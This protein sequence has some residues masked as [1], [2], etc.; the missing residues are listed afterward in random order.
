MLLT[1]EVRPCFVVVGISIEMLVAP[2][3]VFGIPVLVGMLAAVDYVLL[4]FTC[5]YGFSAIVR[6]RNRRLLASGFAAALIVLHAFVRNRCNCGYCA[7]CES[8]EGH[9]RWH[10]EGLN[11]IGH[12]GWL[13]VFSDSIVT[14]PG[15][16]ICC[17]PKR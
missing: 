5:V 12:F 8:N 14:G 2:G 3:A 15:A 16:V 11:R 6:A 1:A 9:F 13:L 10:D 4:L 7:V 17:E